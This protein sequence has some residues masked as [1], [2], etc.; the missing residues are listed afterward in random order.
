ML[1]KFAGKLL[2][3]LIAN[4]LVKPVWILGIDRHVQDIVGTKAYG[5]YAALF[6]FS[7][8]FSML[9]DVG[10]NQYANA[11]VAQEPERSASIIW[12]GIFAE[13]RYCIYHL[14]VV[15]TS[16]ALLVGYRHQPWH[17][18]DFWP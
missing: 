3:L 11:R 6:N 10:I 18:L 12:T 2:L 14:L 15:A 16:A 5:L 1:R 13:I 7:F 4:L 17:V 8:L 9:L